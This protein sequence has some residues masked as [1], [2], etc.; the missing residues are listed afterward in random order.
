MVNF[1]ESTHSY[2][3][4]DSPEINWTSVTSVVGKLHEEFNEVEGALKSSRN[5]KSKWYGLPVEEIKKA[6]KDENTRSK[7]LGHWY[8]KK[9]EDALYQRED[10][11]VYMSPV[12]ED[13]VKVALDQKLTPGLYP[14]H[15]VYLISA[16]VC[17][18]SDLV[19][20]T[21][22]SFSI[23][24]YKTCKEIKRESWKNWEG[25]SKKMLGVCK[26]LDD[27]H[28]Y[29]YAIQ[30]S[31]YAYIIWRANPRLKVGKLTIEHVKF[32]EAGRDKYDY[33]IY[34][35]NEYD[36]CIVKDIELIEV[37]YLGSEAQAIINSYRQK[38]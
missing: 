6:W 14:E 10:R 34:K 12:N 16:G 35:K 3:S 9:R 28:F 19:E 13:N 23:T 32:E 33:P 24:D 37:P 31:L 5:K 27:C 29:H 20:V 38:K 15:L 26:H 18:Q 22:T 36:E 25:D 7:D 21:D 1:I 4:P 11:A 30:L 2:F 8:H 17:G